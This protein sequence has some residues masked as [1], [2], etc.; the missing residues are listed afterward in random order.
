MKP[1]QTLLLISFIL[2]AAVI[3]QGAAYGQDPLTPDRWRQ[4]LKFMAETLSK[5]HRDAFYKI[6]SQD[7]EEAVSKL[8]GEIPRLKDHE[9]IVGLSRIAAMI[10]DGHTRLAL[11]QGKHGGFSQA[12][13]P[14]P[15]VR[16]PHLVFG[17]YPVKLYRFKEGLF[18]RLATTDYKHILG[19]KVIRI[20][21]YTAGE[22]LKKV[23]PAIH[24][25]NEIGFKLHGPTRL[26]IPEVLHALKVTPDRDKAEFEVETLKGKRLK[27][28]LNPIEPGAE[29]QWLDAGD[30]DT[31][32]TG[33]LYLEKSQEPFSY[34]YLPD[35]KT[36]FVQVNQISNSSKMS[37]AQFSRRVVAAAEANPL[38]RFVLDIRLNGGGDNTLNRS[39]VL[40]IVG[41]KKINRYG[42]LYT[43]I[44]RQ[45]FSAAMNLTGL[46]EQMTNTLFVGEPTGTTPSH[47]GDSRKFTLPNSGLTVRISSVYWRDW[48][49]DEKRVSVKPDIPAELSCNDYRARRDP[50]LQAILDYKPGKDLKAQLVQLLEDS[51][52]YGAY[53][54]Y[55][56]FK[57][58][59]QTADQSTEAAVDHL[60]H[61]LLEKKRADHAILV[62]G[63]NSRNYPMSYRSYLGLGRAYI[64]KGDKQKAGDSLKK[65]LDLK[66][67]DGEILEL[68]EKVKGNS[69]S[70]IK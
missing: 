63:L 59:P 49:P 16:Y 50:A 43:I 35:S 8:D 69:N 52:L 38:D 33:P 15:Q 24:F 20:G 23:R 1:I 46:M 3:S 27:V 55:S 5:K 18:I 2:S 58:S 25:D 36:L 17:Q 6:S 32:S 7:F 21:S 11:P 4:D 60:G 51:G 54:R 68:L 26:T 10:G 56:K 45:T 30:G 53:I 61:R 41:S 40:G 34:T 64:Q 12:H 70:D 65:A 44:G 31:G 39:L 37:L 13:T 57:N 22:A 14:T 28:L 42:T 29:V 67:G 19:A 9:I 66:P 48:S 62:F 47:F